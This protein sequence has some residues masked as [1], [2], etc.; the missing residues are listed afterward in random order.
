[1][2]LEYSLLGI[3]VKEEGLWLSTEQKLHK[4]FSSASLHGQLS[5]SSLSLLNSSKD[6]NN[7]KV[8]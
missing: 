7:N 1:M 5:L 2:F 8:M 3:A 4:S 6:P